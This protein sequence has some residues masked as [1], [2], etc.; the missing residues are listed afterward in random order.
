MVGDS[1]IQLRDICEA[2]DVSDRDARYVLERGHVPKGVYVKPA[3][4]NHRQFSGGQAVW[5]GVVLKLKANDISTPVGAKVAD[6]A[7]RCI[8][9]VTQNLGWEPKFLPS[10]GR[11][12]T[13]NGYKVE[14]ADLTFIRFGTDAG[15]SKDGYE[16]FDWH[17][18]EKPGMPVGNIRPYVVFSVD[19]AHI[20]RQLSQ[21]F[22]KQA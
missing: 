12:D 9:T 10:H 1:T 18:I 6:Y 17:L 4:G 14:I 2:L 19:L 5:L 3:S 8:Q 15:P 22:K 20:A 11:L 13:E 7:L 21:A 16:W